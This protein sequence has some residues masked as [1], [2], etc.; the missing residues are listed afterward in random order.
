MKTVK[1]AQTPKK[2]PKMANVQ[3]FNVANYVKF[4]TGNHGEVKGGSFN[5][6]LYMRILSIKTQL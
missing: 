4:W 5:V 1:R 2:G 3:H 6:A